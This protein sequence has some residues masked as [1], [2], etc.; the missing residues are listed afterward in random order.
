MITIEPISSQEA[1]EL[2]RTLTAALPEYFGLPECNE[3]Y[4]Q[5]V[6]SRKNLAAKVDGRTVG[7]LSLEFPYP[8]SG[9]IYWMAVAPEFQGQGVGHKLVEA[10]ATLALE[11]GATTLTVETLAPQEADPHYLKTY[12]FYERAGFEPL[13]NLKPEGY[14]W[15]MVYM[16][17]RLAPKFALPQNVSI[18]PFT[19]SHIPVIVEAFARHNWPKPRA[20]FEGYLKDQNEERRVVWI[21][22]KDGQ[23]A[24][25]VTLLWESLYGPFRDSHIP[26]IVDLNVLPPFRNGG[27]ASLLLDAPEQEASLRGSSVGLGV[28]LYGGPDGGYGP[29]QKLYIKRGYVPDGRGVTSNYKPV[30]PGDS[31]P[32]DDDLVLWLTKLVR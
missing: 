9:S 30:T 6:K 7:L 22:H 10:A 13:F 19:E 29:A 4:A 21:A 23:F 14:T 11:A 28:G 16:A 15:T 17:K 26:E 31:V 2:C 1:E 3:V 20:T 8:Q 32:I 27:I 24:G 25:Y 5:G 18:K 12:Q